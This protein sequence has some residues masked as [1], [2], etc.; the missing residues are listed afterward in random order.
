MLAVAN[1]LTAEQRIDKAVVAIMGHPM[2]VAL[3]GVLMIGKREVRDDI[4]TAC[5]NGRDE[6]YGREF[7][8]SLTDA[9]LRFVILHECYHKMYKHLITWQHLWRKCAMTANKAM[10]HV[11]N[12][13]I[14]DSHIQDKFVVG[15]EGMCYDIKYRDW[16]VPTVFDDIYQQQQGGQPGDGE[17]DGTGGNE[18]TEGGQPFDEHDWEGAED[19]TEEE[20]EG[21]GKEIDEAIRQGAITAGKM[22]SGGERTVADLLEPQVDWREVLREFITTHCT[23]S[24]YATYNRPNRRSMHTGIYFP[25]G[26]SEQVDELV[27]AIDTSGSIGQRELSLFLSEIKSICETVHPKKLRVLYW[28]TEVC[29]A[30]EYEMH[31]LHTLTDSTKP[32]GGGGTDVNCVTSYLAD[33]NISPQAAIMLTDGYLWGGWGTWSCPTLWCVLDSGKVSECGKTVHIKS[34]DMV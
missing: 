34:G 9:Q 29:R 22:G 3:A 6:Y 26:V 25:S 2:Y 12:L 10:D 13:Q 18:S 32:E 19:M 16:N 7:V 31:D 23:G 21:H 15:I 5:T 1:N 17:D 28:D 14:L 4:P 20:K 11:I 30:E 24:D 27:V 33:N 8:D